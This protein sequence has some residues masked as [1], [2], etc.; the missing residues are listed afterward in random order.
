VVLAQTNPPPTPLKMVGDHWTP[1]DPPTDLPEGARVH[2]V[3]PG[4][5]LWALA[6]EHLGDPYLWPQIW[7]RNPYITDSHW[8]YPGDPVVID[9]AVQA[10][11]ETIPDEEVRPAQ[12]VPSEAP[13][14]EEPATDE[15]GAGDMPRTTPQPLGSS[16]DVYCFAEVYPRDHEFPFSVASAERIQFQGHFATGDIVYIDGGTAEGVSAGDQFSIV[17][18]RKL[19]HHPVSNHTL[20]RLY[21]QVGRLKVL[22]AR[23][24]TS[25]C[26]ITNACDPI[27]IGDLL[28]PYQ[29]VPIPLVVL[30]E[31]TDRCDEP[32][33]K[34][35]G[36][37]VH[38]QDH[39]ESAAPGLLVMVDLGS[40]AG[41]YPGQFATIFRDNPV[42]GLPRLIIGELGVLRVG[43]NYATARVTR[44]W[45]PVFVGDRVELK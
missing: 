16:A 14:E 29:S 21:R 37:V 5:T 44:G 15:L 28:K 27:A 23:E 3:V 35:T 17:S 8:I 2:T 24:H 25:I 45:S 32:N 10:A 19:L 6:E 13:V 41:V 26:E 34:P 31:A 42:E 40:E 4:D 36:Y 43:D 22:C 39:I 20:G 1:Y 33:G 38:N 18:P 12:E 7:E 9:V 11:P 30:P